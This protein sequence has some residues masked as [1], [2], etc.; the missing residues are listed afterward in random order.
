MVL[1]PR[2]RA[3]PPLKGPAGQPV[4]MHHTRKA[5]MPCS[6]TFLPRRTAELS[7]PTFEEFTQHR[8]QSSRPVSLLPMT[9]RRP[10]P[11]TS[12]A[13]LRHAW[14][15]ILAGG[16]GTRFWPAS[17]KSH[18]KQFLRIASERSLLQETWDRLDGLIPT[19]RRLVVCAQAHAAL[20]KREL[21]KLARENLL[22]EPLPRNTLPAA[23]WAARVI[24]ERDPQ[25][26]QVL[27]PSDHVVS[28]AAA[29]RASLEAALRFVQSEGS[30]V[31]FGV[32]PTMPATGFGWIER[33]DEV[34][35]VGKH[36]FHAVR[37]FVEKP[38]LARAQR[39]LRSGKH[40]WNA[41]MF[42]WSVDEF[43]TATR[44]HA[45]ALSSLLDKR[46]VSKNVW[47]QL[48]S[49]SVDHGVMEHYPYVSVLPITWSWSDVGSWPA[50]A[51]L[52]TPD[53][54]KNCAS[55]G[56]QLLAEESHGNIV[57]ADAG[58]LIAYIL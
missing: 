5:P 40:A 51:D 53:D 48:P 38:K 2:T 14:A 43:L 52:V 58:Q 11:S 18:P 50:L 37:R 56:V 42:A 39:F 35:R 4:D 44:A 3:E 27:L 21:P 32:A 15:V 31:T 57:H 13:A 23:V 17:R 16:S 12:P 7:E 1:P 36:V 49:I 20:V 8:A 6:E 29:C 33:G 46:T 10:K 9:A 25:A 47:S 30:L 24:A 26:V 28:P 54:A 55:G 22:A 34:A 41:G 19:E 45:P